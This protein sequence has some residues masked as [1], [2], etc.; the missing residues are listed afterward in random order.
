MR[1]QEE[2]EI[3]MLNNHIERDESPVDLDKLFRVSDSLLNKLM[4]L[5]LFRL[6][7]LQIE[8]G[9][10]RSEFALA[11]IVGKSE[12]FKKLSDNRKR[13]LRNENEML[14]QLICIELRAKEHA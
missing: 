14:F 3:R 12:F 6:S 4:P 10:C 7:E 9:K 11:S 5:E 2:E 13:E 1:Q 8:L